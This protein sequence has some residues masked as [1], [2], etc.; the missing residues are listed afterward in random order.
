MIRD[1]LTVK[2][3]VNRRWRGEKL[4][5]A[6]SERR[7]AR[8]NNGFVSEEHTMTSLLDQIELGC[9]F[10]AVL[11]GCSGQCCGAWCINP[12]HKEISGHCG[13][14]SGYRRNQHFE[15]SQFIA[16][17]FDTGD[18]RSAFE[19]LVSRPLIAE[20]VSF[21]YTTLSHTVEHPKARAVFIIDAAVTDP[22]LYRRFKRAVMAKMPW[23]DA[24]VHDPARMVYGSNPGS[25]QSVFL[26]NVLPLMVLEALMEEHRTE[27]EAEQ[28][29]RDLPRISSGRIFGATP[30]ER[31]IN[32]AIQQEVAWV[33]NQV[34]GTG[35][36]HAGLLISSMK[37]ASLSIS[38]WLPAE[39]REGIDPYAL[40]LLAAEANGYVAKYGDV[41]AR[42]TIA[43]G[44]A[45]ARPRPDPDTQ[46][47][48]KPRLRW[49][50]G[51]WVKAVRV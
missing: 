30:A 5:M 22:D 6:P 43:D 24:S 36:R 3:G 25:G 26:G 31:Y 27:M 13:R 1:E 28:P 7:W 15:S 10:T 41:H 4:G 37:L 40:L 2:V 11:G 29:R 49:S 33:S 48:T 14:P 17:D 21:L 23:G 47:S 20:Y 35:Q 46:I 18:E 9:S 12:V 16:L 32:R 51:Q 45:Y 42:Q 34:E 38:E 50:G 8:Y 39:A 19:Y 44:I